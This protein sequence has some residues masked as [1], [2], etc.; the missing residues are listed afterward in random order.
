MYEK[1]K[2]APVVNGS[3]ASISARSDMQT[4]AGIVLICPGEAHR[5]V[6]KNALQ[7]QHAT[8]VAELSVYPTYDHLF[9]VADM[10]CDGFIVEIDGDADAAFDLVEAICGRRPSATVMVYSSRHDP[11]LLV[12]S[13]RAGARE[14]LTGAIPPAVL[15]E[16]LLRASARR[17]ESGSKKTRGKAIVFRGAKGGSGVTTLATNFA[18][19]LRQ[20]T[21]EN[22]ALLDLNPQLGD[23]AVLLGVTP[24]FTIADALSNPTRLDQEFVST[25]VTEHR[26]GV[27]VIAAPDSYG[28]GAPVEARAIGRLVDLVRSKYQYVVIDAGP[29]LGDAAEPLFQIAAI[30]YLVTQSDIPSLRNTQRFLAYLQRF[31]GPRV[32]LV[33]NRFESRKLEFDDERLGKAVGMAPSWKIPNDYAVVGR[34]S[35]TGSPVIFEKTPVANVLR[36][37][38]R[39]ACGKPA[40]TARKKNFSLFGL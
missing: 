3:N 31:G 26:S 15:S 36:Q 19:A 17:A 32:E 12:S 1:T 6:L 5:H 35:N 11:D 37:M 16:A 23:V 24:R 22:V 33:L 7:A 20:E 9:A 39:A 10:E 4:E 21:Q 27:S 38:A 2:L 40:E 28:A 13:M 29:G 18:I 30:V 34:A 14:F 25:L 8:I